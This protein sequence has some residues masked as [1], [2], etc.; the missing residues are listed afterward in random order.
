MF[1][2]YIILLQNI[3]YLYLLVTSEVQIFLPISS[4]IRCC[5]T[6]NCAEMNNS[7]KTTLYDVTEGTLRPSQL[8]GDTSVEGW[9]MYLL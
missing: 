4:C 6:K 3:S 5:I 8:M 1:S 2:I 9:M 7:T